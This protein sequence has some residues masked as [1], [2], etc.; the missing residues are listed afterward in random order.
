MSQT[1]CICGLNTSQ[2]FFFFLLFFNLCFKLTQKRR[3]CT[4]G[5]VC[6]VACPWALAGC[7]GWSAGGAS[8][9]DNPTG[10]ARWALSQGCSCL[11]LHLGRGETVTTGAN[12]IWGSNI[13]QPVTSAY[14]AGVV[15]YY[16]L[17]FSLTGED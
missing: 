7:N 5:G 10:G 14:T 11:C 3:I 8:A 12:T 9:G 16:M 4:Q 17:N 1:K 6:K 2:W 13:F 15:H